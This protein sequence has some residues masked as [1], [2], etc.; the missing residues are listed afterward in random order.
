MKEQ[1]LSN[2]YFPPLQKKDLEMPDEKKLCTIVWLFW[3][4][5]M[6][7]QYF[8]HHIGPESCYGLCCGYRLV[9]RTWWQSSNFHIHHQLRV[10]SADEGSDIFCWMKASKKTKSL[11]N[12]AAIKVGTDSVEVFVS[13]EWACRKIIDNDSISC[14]F[15]EFVLPGNHDPWRCTL[16]MQGSYLTDVRAID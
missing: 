2:C 7:L 5:N 4:W 16:C 13:E 14:Q 6:I 9:V 1:Q 15:F 10:H 8:V 3:M 11:S 12:P